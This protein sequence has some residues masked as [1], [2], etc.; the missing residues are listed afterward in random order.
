M[1]FSKISVC[2]YLNM[3]RISMVFSFF[4]VCVNC[5]VLLCN[6]MKYPENSE[7][8]FLTSW[9]NLSE[10]YLTIYSSFYV[11]FG[12][13]FLTTLGII[14]SYEYFSKKM[15]INDRHYFLTIG[16]PFLFGIIATYIISSYN[17]V[18]AHSPG[19]G[20]SIL[21]FSLLLLFIIYVVLELIE[22]SIYIKY[23][24]D[25]IYWSFSLKSR[26]LLLIA[27][28]FTSTYIAC[29]FY[30]NNN[31]YWLLHIAGFIIFILISTVFVLCRSLYFAVRKI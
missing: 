21:S 7:F 5:I 29:F 20:S 26:L 14:A 8:T 3:F 28:L 27:G 16:Y 31:P 12:I 22:M 23:S 18:Y 9:F 17:W 13:N 6:G 30:I 15:Y 19:S 10:D 2:N 1:K 11:G 4:Y 25:R 24:R